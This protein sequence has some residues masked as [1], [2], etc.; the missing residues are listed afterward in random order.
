MDLNRRKTM[1]EG[2]VT[3]LVISV[4]ASSTSAIY[5]SMNNLYF[6]GKLKSALQPMVDG[7]WMG[8][9]ISGGYNFIMSNAIQPGIHSIFSTHTKKTPF[10]SPLV[11]T[12]ADSWGC[13]LHCSTNE[14]KAD[15]AT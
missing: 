11:P 3:I 12:G 2:F 4:E 10:A 1:R 13:G 15:I 7:F 9:T 6:L 14:D 5:L 8:V